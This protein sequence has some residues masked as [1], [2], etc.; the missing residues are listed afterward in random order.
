MAK[1]DPNSLTKE[2]LD[3]AVR[4]GK[5]SDYYFENNTLIKEIATSN[6]GY[7]LKLIEFSHSAGKKH[8]QMD[9]I[10]NSDG[11]LIDKRIHNF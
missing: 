10:Y 6:G 4:S 5:L 9:F 7:V 8:V 1:F 2:Q 11:I 3:R